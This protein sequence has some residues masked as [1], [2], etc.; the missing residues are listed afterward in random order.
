MAV[1]SRFVW[2]SPGSVQKLTLQAWLVAFEIHMLLFWCRLRTGVY[3]WY[4][5]NSDSNY[6]IQL[7]RGAAEAPHRSWKTRPPKLKMQDRRHDF[8]SWS[9]FFSVDR[10]MNLQLWMFG[11]CCFIDLFK[12][13]KSPRSTDLPTKELKAPNRNF[14]CLFD[15]TVDYCH[16]QFYDGGLGLLEHSLPLFSPHGH[17]SYLMHYWST[18]R[19]RI[20]PV[21][22]FSRIEKISDTWIFFFIVIQFWL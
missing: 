8:A 16:C 5:V 12:F 7:S 22:Q 13:P 11:I 2:R 1:Y 15:A 17:L 6:S 19:L 18:I 10:P 9:L 14:S 3:G 20:H 4:Q 21:I